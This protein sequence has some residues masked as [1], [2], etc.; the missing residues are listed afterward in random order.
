MRDGGLKAWEARWPLCRAESNN[1]PRRANI[2]ATT[3][4]NASESLVTALVERDRD[5]MKS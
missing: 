1:P 4:R 2:T 3:R 5:L